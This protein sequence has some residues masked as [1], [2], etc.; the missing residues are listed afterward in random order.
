LPEFLVISG[1]GRLPSLFASILFGSRLYHRDAMSM[2]LIAL[3]GILFFLSFYWYERRRSR[4]P[5][6]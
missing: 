1:L 5:E 3:L 6:R 4:P 2:T